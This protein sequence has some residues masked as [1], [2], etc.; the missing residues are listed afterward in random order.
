MTEFSPDL[1]RQHLLD[2]DSEDSIDERLRKLTRVMSSSNMRRIRSVHLLE[3][4]K[5]EIVAKEILDRDFL[6]Q[7]PEDFGDQN[8]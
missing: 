6:R 8:A 3:V 5:P 7:T 2:K 4:P 1:R